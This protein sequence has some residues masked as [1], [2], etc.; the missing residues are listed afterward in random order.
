MTFNTPFNPT[1]YKR[2]SRYLASGRLRPLVEVLLINGRRKFK[3]RDTSQR[4]IGW[5]DLWPHFAR[6]TVRRNYQKRCKEL[7]FA[8]SAALR[9]GAKI[10]YK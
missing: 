1:R 10:K 3:G 7:S 8:K 5:T 6:R 2:S 9:K 4:P